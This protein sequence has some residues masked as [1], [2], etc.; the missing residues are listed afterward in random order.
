[1]L[2]RRF[3]QVEKPDHVH[4]R[5]ERGIG[6]RAP[7]VHLRREME[8]NLRPCLLDDRR[9]RRARR[10][11]RSDRNVAFGFTCLRLPAD[12]SSST[13]TSPAPPATSA[14]TVFE[15]IKPAP[16][17]T[18]ILIELSFVLNRMAPDRVVTNFERLHQIRII[19]VPAVEYHRLFQLGADSLKIGMPELIPF[20][21][22]QQRVGALSAS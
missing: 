17:V 12:K 22:D 8:N 5:V 4:L 1:M 7:H 10:A 2:A 19:K 3:Y 21:Q 16:P 11:D 6:N 14:S 15:P 20:S 9:D 13:E 18:R